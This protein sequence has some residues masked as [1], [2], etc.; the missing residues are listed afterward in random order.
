MNLENISLTE[1]FQNYGLDS[2]TAIQLSTYLEKLLG[3]NI[4]SNWFIEYLNI[5]LLSDKL[6]KQ[7]IKNS[8]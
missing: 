5:N 6:K 4:Q 2:I 1:S 8:K 3:F 7:T